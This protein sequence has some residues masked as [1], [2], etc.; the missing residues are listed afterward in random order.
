MKK[1]KEII[2]KECIQIGKLNRK[3][4][5][6]VVLFILRCILSGYGPSLI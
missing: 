5:I 4:V 2:K 6:V 3:E 1:V